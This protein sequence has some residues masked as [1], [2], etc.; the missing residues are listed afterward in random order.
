MATTILVVI[1]LMTS[2]VFHNSTMAWDGGMRKAQA[3][4]LA[5]GVLG[6]VSREMSMAIDARGVGMQGQQEFTSSRVRFFVLGIPDRDVNGARALRSIQ[7]SYSG[8][9]IGR[10]QT[11]FVWSGGAADVGSWTASAVTTSTMADGGDHISG[12]TFSP[13]F[14]PADPQGL[15]LHVD[16]MMEITQEG[17]VSYLGAW[18]LGANGEDEKGLGDD[19]T[20]W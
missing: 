5:R 10:T 19:I 13:S 7:Y 9:Q 4:M 11:D 17:N 2:M 18:S 12:L 15:P 16:I 1:V 8:G 3:G 20:S 6:A 14:D